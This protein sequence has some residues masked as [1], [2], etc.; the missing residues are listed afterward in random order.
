MN[1]VHEIVR[2]PLRNRLLDAAYDL[3]VDQGWARLRMTH[4]AKAADVSRA[5]VHEHFP[6]L[7]AVGEELIAREAERFL[8]GIVDELSKHP[9]DLGESTRVGAGFALRFAAENPLLKRAVGS[10]DGGDRALLTHLTTRSEAVF[11]SAYT[12]IAAYVEQAWPQVEPER[13]RLL[14]DAAVRL[15]ISHIVAPALPV[16]V[17]ARN[18]ADITVYIAGTRGG[19]S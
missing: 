10:V 16:P 3:V 1:H 2:S 13:R 11:D 15:T 9:D 7:D 12:L 6:S 8:A 14:V 17:A 18:I 19:P 4:I 5:V